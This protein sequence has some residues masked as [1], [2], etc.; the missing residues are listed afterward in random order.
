V[1]EAK[2]PKPSIQVEGEDAR[3]DS[4]LDLL[5]L[6]NS[7]LDIVLLTPLKDAEG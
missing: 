7:L 1:L 2:T 6:Q 5:S 4:R 3:I